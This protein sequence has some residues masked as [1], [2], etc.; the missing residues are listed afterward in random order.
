[1][2]GP[3]FAF[4]VTGATWLAVELLNLLPT[5]SLFGMV[6]LWNPLFGLAL[7]FVGGGI[8]YALSLTAWGQ[9]VVFARVWLPLTGRLPVAVTA[10]LDDAYRRGVLR[11]AGAVYQFR[12]ARLQDHLTNTF[13]AGR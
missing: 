9:W 3:V 6:F 2:F 1:V 13:T 8:G 7:G 4:V 11:R 10:F 12:H 5:E